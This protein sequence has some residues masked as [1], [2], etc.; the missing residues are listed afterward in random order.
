[1]YGKTHGL[2]LGNA[3]NNPAVLVPDEAE[4]MVPDLRHKVEQPVREKVQMNIVPNSLT[5]WESKAEMV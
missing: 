4:W 1:M 2:H 5:G 3:Q